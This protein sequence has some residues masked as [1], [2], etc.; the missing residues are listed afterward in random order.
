M[1]D[2]SQFLKGALD[3]AFIEGQTCTIELKN[4]DPT[5]FEFIAAWIYRDESRITTDRDDDAPAVSYCSHICRVYYLADFLGMEKLLEQLLAELDDAF[6]DFRGNN[7]ISLNSDLVL[8]VFEHTPENSPLRA[9]V[10]DEFV[11]I[12]SDPCANIRVEEFDECFQ[13]KDL[14]TSLIHGMQKS[15]H[16]GA[17]CPYGASSLEGQPCTRC[18][19]CGSCYPACVSVSGCKAAEKRA[20]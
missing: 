10:R 6:K 13:I 15:F 8:N 4:E 16:E 11:H 20:Q 14:S 9:R 12:L 7:I 3:G 19:Q 2:H 18:V 17:H 1:C 5:C